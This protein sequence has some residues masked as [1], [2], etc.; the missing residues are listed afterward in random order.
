VTV[1][2]SKVNHGGQRHYYTCPAG[3]AD[4]NL[5]NQ[6]FP[7]E[8]KGALKIRGEERATRL[9]CHPPFDENGD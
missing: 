8:N 7:P 2:V 3:G 4:Y 9:S 5:F 6:A 1:D